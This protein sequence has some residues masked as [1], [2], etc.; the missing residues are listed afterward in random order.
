[1]ALRPKLADVPIE[2]W[3]RAQRG[4]RQSRLRGKVRRLARQRFGEVG[5]GPEARCR[6]PIDYNSLLSFP[7]GLRY[8]APMK[9][10][11][12]T[13]LALLG[14]YW[15]A[16]PLIFT[17]SREVPSGKLATGVAT[18]LPLS[19]WDNIRGFDHAEDCEKARGEML[20]SVAGSSAR[21]ESAS[22]ALKSCDNRVAR[23]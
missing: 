12:A 3:A 5:I 6:L 15:L 16:P 2:R 4:Q 22:P 13:A 18:Y 20:D 21:D 7:A 23:R 9:L 10:R 11:H 19:Q 1:M 17:A 8:K 14:W